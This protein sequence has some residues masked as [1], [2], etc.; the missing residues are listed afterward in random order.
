[1]VKT[2]NSGCKDRGWGIKLVSSQV[3]MVQNGGF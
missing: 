1:M 2:F 3:S